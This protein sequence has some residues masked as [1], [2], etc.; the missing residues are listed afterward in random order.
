M[1]QEYQVFPVLN[2]RHRVLKWDELNLAEFVYF[3]DMLRE[4]GLF[5][6]T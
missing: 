6:M 1:I 5:G 2:L 3:Q 4:H